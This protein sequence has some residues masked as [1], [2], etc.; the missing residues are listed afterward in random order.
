[1]YK[2]N[3]LI[4]NL[5][6]YRKKILPI[7]FY[8]IIY[9]IKYFKSGNNYKIQDHN[10]RTDAIPCPYFF[11]REITKFV[12]QT[13]NKIN[14]NSNKNKKPEIVLMIGYPACGKSSF[15]K[16]KYNNYKIINQDA[17][18]TKAKCLKTLK[19]YLK[20][21]NNIVIDNLN[22]DIKTRKEYIDL[23]KE[24]DYFIKCYYFNIG[25]DICQHLNNLRMKLFNKEK[26]PDIVYRI[27]DKN[28]EYPSLNEGFDEVN[29]V[30]FSLDFIDEKHKKEFFM[31]S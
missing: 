18:K 3:R 31:L 26:I 11:I 5:I 24:K 4:L 30:L 29:E 12:N 16:K 7:I 13:I 27:F 10:I 21:T 28:F 20:Q 1:M 14:G 8:E 23:A 17:L 9:S 25:L 22:Q 2:I 15:T 6:N 19:L